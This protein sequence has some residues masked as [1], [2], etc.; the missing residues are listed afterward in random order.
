MSWRSNL[1]DRLQSLGKEKCYSEEA[2]QL[3]C[4]TVPRRVVF[5]TPAG[6][7]G[8]IARGLQERDVRVT[9]FVIEDTSFAQ[10]MQRVGSYHGYPGYRE[11]FREKLL[12]KALQHYCAFELLHLSG[13]DI[14]ID[15]ASS[16]SP[17]PEIAEE[18]YHCRVYRQ[19]M[20][21]PAGI[22]GNVIGSDAASIPLPDGFCT[23][24]GLHCSYEHFEGDSDSL[25]I[26]EAFRIMKP[27]GRLCIV[28]CY[29]SEEYYILTDPEMWL[30]RG[31]IPD[32]DS[33]ATLLFKNLL[34]IHGRFYDPSAF[35]E[36]VSACSE[37]MRM[38]I[39]KIE[40]MPDS[41]LSEYPRFAALLVK[42]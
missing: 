31:Y 37:G 32:F 40:I 18:L 21:Y 8:A 20:R 39:C 15:V 7:A 33:R 30:K 29:L 3:Y 14:Y 24:L 9:P 28:P 10:Y 42:E 6:D 41:N 13:D 5:E 2:R 1:L 36:R 27:G 19:D 38:N 12:K 17:V 35:M 16:N 26:R 25:F 4:E 34:N 22:H 23:A 11:E